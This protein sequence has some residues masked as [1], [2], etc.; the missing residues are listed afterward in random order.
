MKKLYFVSF[1]LFPYVLS[2]SALYNIG[3][4]LYFIQASFLYTM[5]PIYSTEYT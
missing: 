2:F 1:F 5:I 3:V 4:T